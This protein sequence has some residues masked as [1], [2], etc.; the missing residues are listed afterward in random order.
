MKAS[1]ISIDCFLVRESLRNIQP[2]IVAATIP[3]NL[4]KLMMLAGVSM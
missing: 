4:M 1:I 2:K 3:N